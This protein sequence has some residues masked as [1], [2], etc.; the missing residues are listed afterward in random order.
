MVAALSTI[1]LA[2]GTGAPSAK[3]DEPPVYRPV[4]SDL[5]NAFIQPRHIKL[6]L[7]GK[8]QNWEYAEYERH[9]IGGALARLAKA[10]PEYQGKPMNAMIAAFA[11]PQLNALAAAIKA[12]DQAAFEKG[13]Q[14]LTTGCNQCHQAA[15]HAM[16]VIQTPTADSYPDQ[17]FQAPGK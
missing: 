9:N 10:I 15:G 2:A 16:V 5:M 7:A 12:E 1:A 6:W 14:D 4:T 3:K 17:V 8:A 13:Y 11:T